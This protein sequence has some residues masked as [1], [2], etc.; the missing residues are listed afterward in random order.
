M[1]ALD[2]LRL[3]YA[4]A[5]RTIAGL[6]QIVPRPARTVPDMARYYLA[7]CQIRAELRFPLS[8]EEYD[9]T[10]QAVKD[11][12]IMQ[13]AGGVPALGDLP[14]RLAEYVR[15]VEW[16][17]EKGQW[18][19]IWNHAFARSFDV[20]AGLYAR[21]ASNL[22]LQEALQMP[23]TGDPRVL[24]LLQAPVQ[25]ILRLLDE[26]LAADSARL[27]QYGEDSTADR[28]TLSGLASDLQATMVRR[29]DIAADRDPSK[30]HVDFM[31][32][33]EALLDRLQGVL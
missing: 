16:S 8:R 26:K 32:D 5:N 21:G 18:A 1:A 2:V 7:R 14:D 13:P 19:Q 31:L 9:A 30:L 28:R 6:P 22:R 3:A 25:E 27:T 15:G 29:R 4:Q 10:R 12:S 33:L 24:Q 23:Q 11:G 20:A 17:G